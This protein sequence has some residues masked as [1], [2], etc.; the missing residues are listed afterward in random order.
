VLLVLLLRR[1]RTVSLEALVWTLGI[2]LI[3]FLAERVPP[4]SRMLITAF[5]AILVLGSYGRGRRFW[6]LQGVNTA[7]LMA[8]SWLTFVTKTL[9]P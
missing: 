9:P 2:A 6:I 8:G 4:N 3:T 7:L 1:R 5:P